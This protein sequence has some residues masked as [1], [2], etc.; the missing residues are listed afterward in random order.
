MSSRLQKHMQQ[1]NK[2]YFN[3]VTMGGHSIDLGRRVGSTEGDCQNPGQQERRMTRNYRIEVLQVAIPVTGWLVAA[4]VCRSSPART[5]T[6]NEPFRIA[7]D[8]VSN[9][10][11]RYSGCR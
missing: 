4:S 3:D 10:S 6:W 9:A 2:Y 8:A 1:Q 5:S 7:Q 11:G